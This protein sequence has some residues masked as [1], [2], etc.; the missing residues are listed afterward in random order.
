MRA[1]IHEK[2]FVA[3]TVHRRRTF[4]AVWPKGVAYPIL[5]LGARISVVIT[6]CVAPHSLCGQE[7]AFVQNDL[8]AENPQGG[9]FEQRGPKRGPPPEAAPRTLLGTPA[10]QTLSCGSCSIGPVRASWNCVAEGFAW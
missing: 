1:F 9:V 5:N 8:V 6:R 3:R 10:F 7:D 2:W 4:L